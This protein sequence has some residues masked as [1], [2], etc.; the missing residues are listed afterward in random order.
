MLWTIKGQIKVDWTPAGVG[1]SFILKSKWL[2]RYFVGTRRYTD[3]SDKIRL[4]T[5]GNICGFHKSL[6]GHVAIKFRYLC[7]RLEYETA[8]GLKVDVGQR[9]EQFIELSTFGWS[10]CAIKI[11]TKPEF[12]YQYIGVLCAWQEYAR[13]H[14]H[15]RY[16]VETGSHYR[17]GV[18]DAAKQWSEVFGHTLYPGLFHRMNTWFI[19]R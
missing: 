2:Y 15:R 17:F 5:I 7:A 1:A 3:T 9:I 13:A 4:A 10:F 14:N 8:F 19:Y 12:V 18:H 11:N 6:I 16:I